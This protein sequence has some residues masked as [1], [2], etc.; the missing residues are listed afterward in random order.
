MSEEQEQRPSTASTINAM[1][2]NTLT[3]IMVIAAFALLAFSVDRCV[4][5]GDVE[6]CL[7]RCMGNPG[8]V[9]A[10]MGTVTP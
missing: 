2:Y 4:S 8:C 6:L 10:C 5:C 9:S 3:A 7:D 1:L